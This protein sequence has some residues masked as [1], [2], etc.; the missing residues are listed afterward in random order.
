MAREAS[1]ASMGAADLSRAADGRSRQALE[2]SRAALRG[3]R[4]ARR[5]SANAMEYA[6]EVGIRADEARAEAERAGERNRRAVASLCIALFGLASCVALSAFVGTAW[7][8]GAG[9]T[10]TA[11]GFGIAYATDC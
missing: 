8:L 3:A 2:D 5:W 9:M 11:A 6:Y 4:D 7:A 1:R 10:L